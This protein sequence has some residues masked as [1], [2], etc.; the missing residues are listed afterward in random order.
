M[1]M[2]GKHLAVEPGIPFKDA[3][4][5]QRFGTLAR[6]RKTATTRGISL[7]EA[8]ELHKQAENYDTL[9]M[10][11]T[12]ASLT[13]YTAALPDITVE[14]VCRLHMQAAA[15]VVLARERV[16]ASQTQRVPVLEVVTVAAASFS[17]AGIR[18][19]Q[20]ATSK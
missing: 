1:N 2:K 10:E 6:T 18:L 12:Q 7:K 8:C 5:V 9:A 3:C 20:R 4:E 15:G 13:R 14:E 16:R 11:R 19:T 17:M